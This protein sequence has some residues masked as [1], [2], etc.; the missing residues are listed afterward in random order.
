MAFE[1][2]WSDGGC[3]LS[4]VLGWV[5]VAWYS[6]SGGVTEEEMEE[7]ARVRVRVKTKEEKGGLFEKK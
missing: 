1:G 4:A 2:N 6:L 5:T 3:V 7:E